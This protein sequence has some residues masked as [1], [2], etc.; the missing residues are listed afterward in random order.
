MKSSVVSLSPRSPTPRAQWYCGAWLRRLNDTVEI[1]SKVSLILQRMAMQ[2][3][4]YHWDWLCSFNVTI[5]SKFWEF[6]FYYGCILSTV[7]ILLQIHMVAFLLQFQSY[8]SFNLTYSMLLL[9]QSYYSFN[10]TMVAQFFL[11]SGT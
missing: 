5:V 2:Y 8:Y 1:D 3:Q 9:F 7:S 6:Q 4:W 10:L 11:G